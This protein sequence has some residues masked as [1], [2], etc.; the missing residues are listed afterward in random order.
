MSEVCEL[1]SYYQ[2]VSDLIAPFSFFFHCGS[3]F[4]SHCTE[5]RMERSEFGQWDDIRPVA[6]FSFPSLGW[7]PFSIVRC[8]IWFQR[9]HGGNCQ[10]AFHLPLQCLCLQGNTY[11][12]FVFHLDVSNFE[13]AG[14]L[15]RRLVKECDANYV[16]GLFCRLHYI[17]VDGASC[18]DR[19]IVV[20]FFISSVSLTFAST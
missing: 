10:S 12:Q 2:A 20:V 16:P 15:R 18:Y 4:L 14:C 13:G 19:T 3:L 17:P 1:G 11:C 5:H 8:C 7:L 6:F 9:S